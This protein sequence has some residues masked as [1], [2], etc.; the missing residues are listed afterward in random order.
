MYVCNLDPA[1]FHLALR[2]EAMLITTEVRKELLQ[3]I[4]QI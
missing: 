1:E 2:C 4:D 3:D